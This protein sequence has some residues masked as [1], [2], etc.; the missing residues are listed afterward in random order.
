M[1]KNPEV[2]V[3]E[4]KNQGLRR[5]SGIRFFV[6]DVDG[7]LTD[8][9]MYYDRNGET[10]KRFDTRDAFG[11]NL[12]RRQGLTLVMITGEKSPIVRIRGRKLGIR[13]VLVGVED[14]CLTLERLLRKLG[15][16]WQNVCYVGDDLNDLAAIRQAGFSACPAD[17]AA[18]VRTAVHYVCS[19]RGGHGAV[20]EVCDIISDGISRD[21]DARARRLA[22]GRSWRRSSRRPE[23]RKLQHPRG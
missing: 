21:E 15:A 17:A 5:H 20:R 23:P 19:N 12:L 16:E 22:S 18:A 2:T 13:H 6:V 7:T 11:M 14:K 9:G 10:M 1:R 8:G 3:T 4:N